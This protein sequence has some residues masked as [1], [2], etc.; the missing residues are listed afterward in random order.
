[1]CI[2]HSGKAPEKQQICKARVVWA[3]PE[4]LAGHPAAGT[5]VDMVAPWV[6]S[7]GGSGEMAA[8]EGCGAPCGSSEVGRKA[9]SN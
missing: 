2:K 6:M 1:L 5:S 8:G 3:V 9:A 7:W 4:P